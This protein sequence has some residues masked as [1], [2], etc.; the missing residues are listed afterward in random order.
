[1]R[2]VLPEIERGAYTDRELT[3]I[4]IGLTNYY[5]DHWQ[6]IRRAS[7]LDWFEYKLPIVIALT[8]VKEPVSIDL[9][10]DF[11]Y[12]DEKPKIRAVLQDFEQFIYK[13]DVDYDGSKQR[14]YRWYHASFFDFIAAKED[15]AD[16]R[17]SLLEGHQKAAD[18]MWKDL[19]E[20]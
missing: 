5:E 3:Q 7:E 12:I 19:F 6:R 4:P 9:L 20:N 15:I 14:R 2:L 13:N 16:E 17:V 18:K 11:S 1:L 8:I 10:S